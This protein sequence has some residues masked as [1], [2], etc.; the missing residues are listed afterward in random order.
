MAKLN[1]RD[2]LQNLSQEEIKDEYN[3]SATPH[4]VCAINLSGDINV[5]MCVRT[6]SLFGMSFHILGR[7]RYDKRTAVGMQNYIDIKKET[8]TIGDHSEILNESVVIEKLIKYNKSYQLVFIEQ[9]G[10]DIRESFKSE[11]E[12]PVMFVIGNEGIGIPRTVID[13]FKEAVIVEIPQLGVGRSHN[14]ACALS[15]ALWEFFRTR[16]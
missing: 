3:K 1:V 10:T 16:M 2:S 4:S 7:R 15:I 8:A 13:A 5:G 12:K 11:F 6:A 9:G 14:V